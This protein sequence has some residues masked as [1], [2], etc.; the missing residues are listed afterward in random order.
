[1]KIK[2]GFVISKIG[3]DTVAVA[4]GKLSKEFPGIVML[5][6][7]GEFLWKQ[8]EKDTDR[9][10][11]LAAMLDYYDVDEA[12]A[13]SDIDTFLETIDSAGILEK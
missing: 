8:L 3:N 1:M 4:T 11:L 13:T 5:N 10:S 6:Q 2:E 12:T 7:S 9:A